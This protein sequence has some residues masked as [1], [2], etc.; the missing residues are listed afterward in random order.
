M[1]AELVISKTS[2]RKLVAPWARVIS[3]AAEGDLLE[4]LTGAHDVGARPQQ[5][6]V[7]VP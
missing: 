7:P 5:G 4:P 1:A 6:E 2:Q 3:A